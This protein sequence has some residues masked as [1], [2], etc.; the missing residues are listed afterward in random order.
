M[1]FL[2][3]ALKTNIINLV[4]NAK[5]RGEDI[6]VANLC[7]SFQETAMDVIISKAVKAAQAFKANQ[8]IIAGELVLT[9][10]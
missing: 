9:L 10:T 2:F 5:Q 3:R 7:T 4:N 1:T 8:V 6:N